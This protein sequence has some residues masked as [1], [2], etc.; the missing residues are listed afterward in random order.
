MSKN[1]QISDRQIKIILDLLAESLELD[2]DV[3]EF[4][5][6]EG[7]T[8]VKMGKLIRNKKLW[9]YDS[10]EGL[11]EKSD[12]DFSS[13]GEAFKAGELKASKNVLMKRFLHANLPR[14]IIK[15][16]W[17]DELNPEQDV[18]EKISFALLDGDFYESIKTSFALVAPK[19]INGGVIIVHD[20]RNPE[21][22]GSAKAVNEFLAQNPDYALRLSSGLAIIT[23]S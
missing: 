11:P 22:P 10:F 17:F 12:A 14:P 6:Y 3:V 7:D 8:S 18:P 15:K 21:L 16:A 4:G 9:L 23:K 5:C 19:L 13:I 20:Y 1:K 2:G